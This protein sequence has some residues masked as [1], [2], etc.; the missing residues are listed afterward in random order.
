MTMKTLNDVLESKE[1][2]ETAGLIGNQLWEQIDP[3]ED[4]TNIDMSALAESAFERNQTMILA[5]LIKLNEKFTREEI[6]YCLQHL[7][8]QIACMSLLLA[9]AS[10]LD[11]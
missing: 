10:Y 9:K 1:F 3:L 11:C 6:T 7:S 8:E 4:K 2:N 5:S